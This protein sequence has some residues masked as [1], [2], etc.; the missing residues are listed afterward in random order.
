MVVLGTSKN[1][2]H[3]G[4]SSGG[5]E[6][7]KHDAKGNTHKKLNKKGKQSLFLLIRDP[8]SIPILMI[9]HIIT[10]NYRNY[11]PLMQPMSSLFNGKITI[12]YFFFTGKLW[13][14]DAINF[15]AL[16]ERYLFCVGYMGRV[17][18]EGEGFCI[19]QISSEGKFNK[20][21]R[22]K[23]LRVI[24]NDQ[25]SNSATCWTTLSPS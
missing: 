8:M 16:L 14:P 5:D 4:H 18:G 11:N 9:H 13:R 24:E 1:E 19:L 12:E 3:W 6:S 25:S 7:R 17:W 15:S 10:I 21:K 23:V 2:A 22:C 20:F